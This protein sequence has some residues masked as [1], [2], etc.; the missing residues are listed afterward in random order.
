MIDRPSGSL[1]P[2]LRNKHLASPSAFTPESLLREARR[3]KNLP[4][5]PIPEVCILDPDGDIVDHVRTMRG[6]TLSLDWACY[7]TRLWEWDAWPTEGMFWLPPRW[8]TQ[9]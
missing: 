3:Q 1:P 9:S 7:H 6:A 2:I 5:S 8:Q 4:N